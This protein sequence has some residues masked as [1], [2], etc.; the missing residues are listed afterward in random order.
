MKVAVLGAYPVNPK[1]V[2][3]GVEEVTFNLVEGLQKLDDLE[4][5]VITCRRSVKKPYTVLR[6]SISIHYLPGQKRLNRSTMNVLDVIRIIRK[7][8]KIKP[9]IIHSQDQGEYT[10]A[11]LMTNYPVVITI[12]TITSE[13]FKLKKSLV[14]RL[15]RK[16]CAGFLENKCLKKAKNIITIS[17]YVKYAISKSTSATFHNIPNPVRDEFYKINNKEEKNRILFAGRVVP[18]KAINVLLEALVIIKETIPNIKLRV[19]GPLME[20]DYYNK[21]KNFIKNNNLNKNVEF[22][23]LLNIPELIDEY[24]KCSIF[25]LPSFTETFSLVIAQALAAGKP[26]VA[27]S[28]GGVPSIISD[29]ETGFLVRVGDAGVFAERIIKLLKDESLRLRMGKNGRKVT[30]ERFTTD[31]IARKTRHVYE[32]VYEKSYNTKGIEKSGKNSC[33]F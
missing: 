20:K 15:L 32:F 31:I 12:S 7:V 27:S 2:C 6:K 4:I 11:A 29:G 18:L 22:L 8:H 28:V 23:G 25:V 26:V 30:S 13:A 9:D 3:G 1:I 33:Y 21:L 19:A 14:D 16:V 10:Q 17:P 24:A 5:H